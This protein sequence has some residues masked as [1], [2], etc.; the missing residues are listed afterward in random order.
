MCWFEAA[1]LIVGIVS[2]MATLGATAIALF[3]VLRDYRQRIDCAFMWEAATNDKPMLILN[4]TGNRTVI[5]ERIDLYFD[6]KKVGGIDILRSHDYC[7]NAIISPNKEA[8][9]ILNTDA[10][11]LDIKGKPVKNPDR[12]YTLTAVV[13]TTNKQRYR[14]SYGYCYNDL[15]YLL[16]AEALN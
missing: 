10:L 15:S 13:T 14:S 2:A 6:K 16:F 1:N 4:N 5:V 7:K 8:R 3:L 12:I 9:M 11:K